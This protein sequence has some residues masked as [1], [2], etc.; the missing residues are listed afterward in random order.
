MCPLCSCVFSTFRIGRIESGTWVWANTVR[1]GAE[2]VIF[3][4]GGTPDGDEV[5]WSMRITTT[6]PET[7]EVYDDFVLYTARGAFDGQ[8]GS[9]ELYYRVAGVRT[10]VLEADFVATSPTQKTLTFSVPEGVGDAG[11]DSVVYERSGDD[12]VFDWTQV[13]EGFTHL[14]EW[15]AVTEAGSI[16]ATN[17]NGGE[18]AC[19]DETLEDVPCD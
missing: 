9:W 7:D 19:W 18:R 1:I 17:Y 4:L 2:D 11:G 5:L 14:V 3:R 16:T 6:D 15:D 12:R 10:R 13:G 8:T